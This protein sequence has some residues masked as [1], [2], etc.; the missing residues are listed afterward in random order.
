MDLLQEYESDSIATTDGNSASKPSG[1]SASSLPSESSVSGSKTAGAKR[2]ADELHGAGKS[3]DENSGQDHARTIAKKPAITTGWK[4]LPSELV[5]RIGKLQNDPRSLAGM[6]GTC[7]SWR[8]IIMEGDA[9]ATF[10]KSSLWRDLA[11]GWSPTIESVAE[12]LVNLP[13]RNPTGAVSDAE[14]TSEFSW[15]G[16]LRAHWGASKTIEDPAP[17]QPHTQLD[18]YIFTVEFRSKDKFLFATSGTALED[19]PS[20]GLWLPELWDQEVLIDKNRAHVEEELCPEIRERLGD[21]PFSD[22]QLQDMVARVL[23]TRV[24]D[25]AMVELARVSVDSEDRFSSSGRLWFGSDDEYS[26][27]IPTT[28][29]VA[30]ER[31]VR[32][33]G[34]AA[35]IDLYSA[36]LQ[37]Q[38]D[39]E[40]GAV[41]MQFQLCRE[42]FIRLSPL[43][44]LMYLEVQCP[45]P[46]HKLRGTPS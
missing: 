20:E 14:G 39:A 38:L 33:F 9:N 45:W 43:Q 44:I 18:D 25:M 31:H 21:Q 42:R 13:P 37:L 3:N 29:L 41:S 10:T 34:E 11:L 7:K 1:N 19:F 23:V 40:T 6:D 36:D 24:S 46:K 4:D 2:K 16:L 17:Y 28:R 5:R 32:W 30:E 27:T 15:K 12:A 35:T 8:K 22:D 26:A